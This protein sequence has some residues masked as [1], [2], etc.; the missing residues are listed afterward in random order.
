M[1][2]VV[3]NGEID[4][5]EFLEM[6]AKQMNAPTLEQEIEEA[7]KI[8]NT[9]QKPTITKNDIRL[10]PAAVDKSVRERSRHIYLWRK[11]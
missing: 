5:D 7:W 2:R 8:F 10:A 3:G 6:M 1:W 11:Q 9:M 4:F